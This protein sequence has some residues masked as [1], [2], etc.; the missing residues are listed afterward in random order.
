MI[1]KKI[2]KLGKRKERVS[3]EE[4]MVLIGIMFFFTPYSMLF[5]YFMEGGFKF[6]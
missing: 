2:I 1:R 3:P 6:G 4:R 5:H